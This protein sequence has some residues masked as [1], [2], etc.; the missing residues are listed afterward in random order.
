MSH[1]SCPI[2]NFE[3]TSIHNTYSTTDDQEYWGVFWV[4]CTS[5]FAQFHVP[6]RHP[7][8]I[9]PLEELELCRFESY[10]VDHGPVKKRS[11]TRYVKTGVKTHA[12]A[13]SAPLAEMADFSGLSC[14][15]CGNAGSL[16]MSLGPVE[17]P[18]CHQSKLVEEFWE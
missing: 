17:C 3:F 4:L 18:K 2:C 11:R 12:F 14:P 5:C 1:C 15:D 10:K 7:R 16:V 6:T 9:S 8:G 13:K